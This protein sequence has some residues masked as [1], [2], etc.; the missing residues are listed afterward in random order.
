MSWHNYGV[1]KL[2]ALL[3]V[4]TWV[5]GFVGTAVWIIDPTVKVALIASMP[6]SITGLAA[7][8]MGIVNKNKI[9][10]VHLTM[11][12]RLDELLRT[13]KEH[14]HDEGRREGIESEQLR[15]R[16]S[17]PTPPKENHGTQEKSQEKD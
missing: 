5:F 12:S 4:A 14:A 2:A 11:N 9:K 13:T 7:F 3:K 15:M 16:P 8:I 1:A 10:E 6:A 17:D